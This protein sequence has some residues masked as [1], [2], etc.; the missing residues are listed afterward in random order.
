[1][2][3]YALYWHFKKKEEANQKQNETNHSK[4]GDPFAL[5]QMLF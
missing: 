1:M 4:R 5:G 2:P 3:L